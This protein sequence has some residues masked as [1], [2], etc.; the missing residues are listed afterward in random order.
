M[1]LVTANGVAVIS[2]QV[3]RPLVG[4]W[5]ADLVI[6]QSDSSG[7]TAGSKVTISADG[8]YTLKGVVDQNRTGTFLDAVHVRVIGGAG[9][10]DKA[11]SARSYVQPGAFVRDVLNG[12]CSDAGETLSSTVD[13][14]FLGTN[15]T[16]WSVIGGNSV[17]RNLR[18]LLDIVAPTLSLRIL[19]DGTLW[20]GSE[21]WPST[22]VVFD[23]M[24]QDPKDGSFQIGVDSP[25]VEPG[26]NLPDV[27]NVAQ[28]MDTI[29]AGRLRSRVWVNFP[30]LERG[31]S[32]AAQSIAQQA[33]AGVDYYASYVCQV[34]SQSS[35]LA[36]VDIS[37]VGARNKALLGGMQ[38]V[39]ARY[40]TGCK[41]QV[42]PGATCLL[43]WD[44]GNPE[45]PYALILSGDSA[46]KIS[47]SDVAND[48]LEIS[49]GTVTLKIAGV[50][51]FQASATAVGLGLVRSLPF[52][53]Q[54]SVDS[55]G[56][57]VTNNPAASASIVR[58]G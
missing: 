45:G 37:P 52:L 53:Y 33:L 25:F 56:V 57:P 26:M 44:G 58:G 29:E 11:A 14:S 1:A 12:L 23:V 38:R 13:A 7:F 8:G 18:A 32:A 39:T 4:V 40:M 19:S 50:T 15:L 16:A 36:T 51:V 47:L 42:S 27:G 2:G 20:I 3:I 41:V 48:S 9:G 30:G 34:V 5:T 10:L 22:S 28:V 55:L 31:T 46:I 17:K 54:G 35:D 24:N 43:G 21:T 49:A 6:D